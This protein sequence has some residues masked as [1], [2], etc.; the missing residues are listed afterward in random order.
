MNE[1]KKP[2][3]GGRVVST[4]YRSA[5]REEEEAKHA[6]EFAAQEEPEKPA[7]PVSPA[8]PAEEDLPEQDD[9]VTDPQD[10]EDHFIAAGQEQQCQEKQGHDPDA[11]Q[12]DLDSFSVFF[13][14]GLLIVQHLLKNLFVVSFHEISFLSYFLS[15]FLPYFL[16]IRYFIRKTAP[17]E[18]SFCS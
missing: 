18:L 5:Y 3:P 12:T 14:K 15:Y 17:A 2:V 1:K 13:M 11:L 7:T 8:A 4:D 6:R 16:P 10:Q 9:F